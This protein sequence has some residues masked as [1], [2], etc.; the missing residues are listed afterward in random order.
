MNKE[1]GDSFSNKPEDPE[2]VKGLKRIKREEG[3]KDLPPLV[4]GALCPSR[5]ELGSPSW[6]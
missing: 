3:E 5:A 1:N 2:K 6:D 4:L